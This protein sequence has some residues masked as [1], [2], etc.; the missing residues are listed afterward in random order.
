MSNQRSARSNS[1]PEVSWK[2]NVDPSARGTNILRP[3][4][5]HL[6]DRISVGPRCVYC[7]FRFYLKKAIKDL[8][9]RYR[10]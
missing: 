5:V 4:I 1:L 10:R 2:D 3:G 8:L 6:A 9:I 7:T